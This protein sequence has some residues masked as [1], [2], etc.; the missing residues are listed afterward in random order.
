MEENAILFRTTQAPLPPVGLGMG[1]ASLWLGLSIVVVAMVQQIVSMM[2]PEILRHFSLP[3]S[4]INM[5]FIPLT[6]V[7][8]VLG[9]LAV[10]FGA[11]SLNRPGLPRGAAAA[12]TA[13]GG[14]ALLFILVYI[15]TTVIRG[16]PTLIG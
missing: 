4:Q 13:L 2:L 7:Q 9:L 6:V 16:L 12:G 3:M 10:I 11:I 1:H 15:G 14:Q 8:G 5:I